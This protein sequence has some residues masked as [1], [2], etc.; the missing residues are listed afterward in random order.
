MEDMV[1]EIGFVNCV[2]LGIDEVEIFVLGGYMVVYNLF[3]YFYL[4]LD[5]G[6]CVIND[7]LFDEFMKD[8]S[9]VDVILNFVFILFNFCYVGVL[10]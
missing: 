4:L 9:K 7:V 2:Y 3:V 6:G 5:F 1:G 8:L 10:S